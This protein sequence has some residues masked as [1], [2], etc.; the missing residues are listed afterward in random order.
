MWRRWFFWLKERAV[1][2]NLHAVLAQMQ[3]N[4][5][6]S[7]DEFRHL[8]HRLITRTLQQAKDCPYYAGIFQQRGIDVDNPQSLSRVPILTKREIQENS[9]ALAN[10]SYRGRLKVVVSSG[11]TGAPGR[12]YRS[13]PSLEWGYASGVRCKQWWGINPAARTIRLWGQ[14][15]RFSLSIRTRTLGRLSGLKNRAVGTYDFA[16]YNL[17]L[18]K[19]QR[20]WPTIVNW[21]PKIIHGYATA[22]Y[23]LARFVQECGLDGRSLGLSGVIVESEKFYSFQRSLIEEVFGCPVLEWYGCCETGVIATPCRHGRLHVREDMVFLEIVNG[24][25]VVTTLRENAVPLI[26]YDTAD[27]AEL[28]HQPC[29]CGMPTAVLA[30]MKGRTCDLIQDTDGQLVHPW[31]IDHILRPLPGIR[32]YKVVQK[33]LNAVQVQVES[34]Q[35]L[36]AQIKDRLIAQ[37]RQQLGAGVTVRVEEVDQIP[38]DPSG[39][40]RWITS[41]LKSPEMERAS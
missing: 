8:Q 33:A 32:K 1:H 21:K 38:T 7:R 25:I 17:T 15:A 28:D 11:S 16:A 23:L 37:F 26:R 20:Q 31:A 36:A 14:S 29:P 4:E 27:E 2:P 34:Q 18:E 24:S 39:K 5:R 3:R 35:P 12:F 40:F 13:R 30:D 22:V 6:L 19:I 9:A 10:R 41:E